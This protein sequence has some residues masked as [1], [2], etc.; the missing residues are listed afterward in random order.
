VVDVVVVVVDVVVV[1]VVVVGVVVV[2]VVVA[3]VVVVDVLAAV[4]VNITGVVVCPSVVVSTSPNPR[5]H[6]EHWIITIRT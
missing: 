1:D 4:V 3:G 6:L 5:Q 2:D